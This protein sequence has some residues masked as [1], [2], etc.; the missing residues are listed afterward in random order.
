MQSSR[1]LAIDEH[2]NSF[3]LVLNCSLALEGTC[4]DGKLVQLQGSTA[5][6]R[7]ARASS[8]D[9]PNCVPCPRHGRIALCGRA[10]K[11]RPSGGFMNSC[12]GSPCNGAFAKQVRKE[13]M[14]PEEMKPSAW[15]LPG[16]ELR[17]RPPRDNKPV[18]KA[19]GKNRTAF[20]IR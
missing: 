15:A 18:L 9:R 14:K 4:D 2:I 10:N 20:H 16:G 8:R 3:T 1:Q 12:C 5:W 7:C 11:N 19:D 17:R 6:F 13:E